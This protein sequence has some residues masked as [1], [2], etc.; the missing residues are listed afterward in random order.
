[1]WVLRDMAADGEKIHVPKVYH[2]AKQKK[3]CYMVMMLLGENLKH[4]KVGFANS[5]TG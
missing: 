4:L 5:K 3:F 2:A 1:M